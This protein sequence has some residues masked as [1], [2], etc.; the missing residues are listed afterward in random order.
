MTGSAAMNN[1]TAAAPESLPGRG[2]KLFDSIQ[3]HPRALILV[4]LVILFAGIPFILIKGVPIYSAGATV[5]VSPRF[6]KTLRDDI[7]LEFQ[8]NTQY[9]Q[10][11]QQQIRTITRY[12]VLSAAL[13]QLDVRYAGQP[14][15]W[16]IEGESER[17]S[18]YRLQNSLRVFHIRDSYLIQ[19]R[20]DS[21][22]EAG[23]EDV[24]NTLIDAYLAVARNEHFF[25]TDQRVAQLDQRQTELLAQIDELTSER[26]VIAQT[27]GVTALNPAAVNPFDRQ[28]QKLL[29]EHIDARTRRIEAET[30]LAAFLT[31]GETDL[32]MRSI[33]ESIL[34]DPGLN[35]LKASLNQRRAILLTTMSGLGENHPARLDARDE[36][37]SIEAEI[38]LREET[39]RVQLAKAIEKRYRN[40]TEQAQVIEQTLGKTIE[41]VRERGRDYAEGYNRALGLNNHIVLLWTE[42]DRV[43]DRLNF[44]KSEEAAPGY[45]RLETAAM[46]AL[47]PTGAGKKKLL[48]VVLLAAFGLSLATPVLL[49][50]LDPRIRTVNDAQ[51]VLGFAPMGWLIARGKKYANDETAFVN[52][53]LRRIA[54]AIIRERDR[55]GTHSIA[56]TSVK[57]GGGTTWMVRALTKTLNQLGYRALALEAN[58]Y[59]P[60]PAYLIGHPMADGLAANKMTADELRA[61]PLSGLRYLLDDPERDIL[62]NKSDPMLP[63]LHTLEGQPAL[64]NLMNM[65]AAL[66]K[67]SD[68][69]FVLVD[70][71]PL[72]TSADAELIVRGCDGG[73][74]VARAG[75]IS[76][77]EL[78]RAVRMMQRI[79]PRVAGAII[80]AIE[81]FRAGGYVSEMMSEFAQRRRISPASVARDVTT[82]LTIVLREAV[83]MAGAT[84]MSPVSLLRYAFKKLRRH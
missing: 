30:R 28:M 36:L 2:I 56:F 41:E 26:T 57:P 22:K 16:R 54:T 82:T 83:A 5:Q 49:D 40:S 1:V 74:I 33:S 50:L 46:P 10:F 25:G 61:S 48:L 8:S 42:L 27:L 47:Y 35:S 37:T 73:V 58:A 75:D 7:E 53:Q 39:L 15:P 65:P 3:R 66:K 69:D 24:V 11:I 60:N 12:D 17:R 81:P 64:N 31:Q 13:K 80:N 23:I 67:F 34:S 76:K 71:P 4:F 20:L 19:V 79:D 38:S 21:P 78:S 63:C 44:F 51:R 59:H 84:L 6:M 18:I 55:H 9:L 52:E 45:V 62:L 29:E 43:R 14:N 68:F 70:A 32:A 77:G 72:L